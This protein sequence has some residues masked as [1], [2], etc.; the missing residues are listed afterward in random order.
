MASVNVR[1]AQP[2]T[3]NSVGTVVNCISSEKQLRR[4]TL[5]ALMFENQFYL[6]GVEHAKL[7]QLLVPKVNAAAVAKLALQARNDF[8]LRHIPLTLMRELAR[9]GKMKAEDLTAIIQRPDEMGEFVAQYWAEKKQPLSNQVKKGLAAAFHKFNEYS[10]AKWNKNSA[11]IKI[12]DVMFM[13]HVKP[14]N[15]A[16]EQLFKRIAEDTL[17]TPDTWEVQLSGGADKKATF[18]RLM[19]DQKLGALAF[20]RNLRGMLEAGVSEQEIRDYAEVVNISRVLPFRF[21][22]AARYAPRLE[23]MLEKMMF[24]ALDGMEKLPGKTAVVI[25]VSGSMFGTPIS[26]KSD[27]ERFEAAAALAILC[28][29]LCEDSVVYSFSNNAVRVAPRRGFALRDAISRSQGH[30]GT[31]LGRSLDTINRDTTYDRIIVLTDE[32][33]YD[34]PD[35]PRGKGYIINVA[36]YQ[37]GVNQTNYTN[38]SGFSESVFEYIIQSE[39]ESQ[40]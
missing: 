21:I 18:S 3:T 6:D 5:A 31:S 15:E 7:I 17:V 35:A 32:Q 4:M 23:D 30:G 19:A 24:R 26:G 40:N 36:A 10:L 1:A 39:K 20:L 12:R 14:Q 27:L 2:K 9:I 37:N 16:Q 11:A 25:D 34:K 22:A 8:K 33:S 29:E 13:T 38:I 28:R